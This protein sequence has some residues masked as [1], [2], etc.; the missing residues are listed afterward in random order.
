MTPSWCG[1][2]LGELGKEKEYEQ[3]MLYET[4]PNEKAV[5]W[6]SHVHAHTYKEEHELILNYENELKLTFA[7][8]HGPAFIW[9]WHHILLK[10]EALP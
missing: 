5:L 8:T 2:E 9:K 7:I 1:E 10:Q 4:I 3:D 6:F